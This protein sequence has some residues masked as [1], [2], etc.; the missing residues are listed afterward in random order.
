MWLLKQ[1]IQ[2]SVLYLHCTD[3]LALLPD[4]LLFHNN[5]FYQQNVILSTASNISF[6]GHFIYLS[7]GT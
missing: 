4:N 1:G 3:L 7:A 2:T 6:G 5:N